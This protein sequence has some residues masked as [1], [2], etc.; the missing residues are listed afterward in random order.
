[1][2]CRR[3]RGLMVRHHM[4]DLRDTEHHAVV[5]RCV[6]CGNIEDRVTLTNKQGPRDPCA[7]ASGHRPLRPV[8][9]G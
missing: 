7:T 4:F 5:W 2:E 9:S 1:M 6:G 8:V 3:C